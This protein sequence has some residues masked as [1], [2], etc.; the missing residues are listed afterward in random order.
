MN[1]NKNPQE[2]PLPSFREK[3]TNFLTNKPSKKFYRLGLLALVFVI[4]NNTN[5]NHNNNTITSMIN[6]LLTDNICGNVNNTTTTTTLPPDL[7]GG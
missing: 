1:D 6:G 3:L 2:F 4:F 5:P 7:S